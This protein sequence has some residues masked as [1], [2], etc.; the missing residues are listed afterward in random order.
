MG[1]RAYYSGP[2]DQATILP[3]RRGGGQV[4]FSKKL[5]K[6]KS[7]MQKVLYSTVPPS[8]LQIS[9]APY[10]S[11]LLATPEPGLPGSLPAPGKKSTIR[12]LID[13]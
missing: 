12:L 7:V 13:Y 8:H 10:S 1:E 3:D 11:S 5:K 9:S 6:S 4:I 2:W